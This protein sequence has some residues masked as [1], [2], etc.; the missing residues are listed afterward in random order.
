[1]LKA[2]GLLMLAAGL[3]G[4]PVTYLVSVNT[5]SISGLPG[6]IDFQFNPGIG[7][8]DP[9]FV[10]ISSFSSDG[11][12]AGSP[13]IAGDVTGTLPPGVTIHNT[14]AFNDYADGFTFGSVLSF[15]VSFDGPALTSPSGTAS[16]G[17]AFGFSL[18]NS[19]FSAPLL[20]ND[21]DGFL[22]VGDVDTRGNVTISNFGVDETTT[23]TQIPEPASAGLIALGL[24]GLAIALRGYRAGTASHR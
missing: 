20:T 15:F 9:A 12:L 22:V 17:S 8:S 6:N 1:M 24:L 2:F 3:Y 11:T 19:D 16:S 4:A 21:S 13:F 5:T 23:V 7:S 14:T 18:F 10:T